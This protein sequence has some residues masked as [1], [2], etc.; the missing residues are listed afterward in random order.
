[1]AGMVIPAQFLDEQGF[2]V[3][4]FEILTSPIY[5]ERH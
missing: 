1:M 2:E 3:K 4:V 5:I